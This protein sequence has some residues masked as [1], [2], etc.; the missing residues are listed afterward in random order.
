MIRLALFADIH[1]KF[2]LPF[3]LVDHYQKQ[4][5]KQ[6]DWIIQCGDMGAFPDKSNMD[7][8]TLRHAKNDRDELGF[9]DDFCQPSPDIEAFLDELNISMLCVRGNHEDHA[10]LDDLEAKC[11]EQ[12]Y[13]PIDC[14]GRVQVLKT[15]VPTELTATK[16]KGDESISLV[17]VGRIGDR[18]GRQH[19]QY[20]QDYERKLLARF[21]KKYKNCDLLISHDKDIDSQR[22]YGSEEI[23]KL[24]DDVAFAYH[25]HGH[26]GEPYHTRTAENGITEIVKIKELEFNTKGKLEAGCMLI[27]EKTAEDFSLSTVPLNDVI[28]FMKNTWRFM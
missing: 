8:A 14:Y 7:K 12:A 21:S 3:K 5:G 22:G 10:F 15:G 16:N 1:G 24:L 11:T 25:F 23:A 18:K 17:G 26:T 13:F 4:T 28:G 19:S 20:I 27:L 2:L 6:F 9:I